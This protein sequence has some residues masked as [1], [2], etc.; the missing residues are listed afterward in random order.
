MLHVIKLIG[1]RFKYPVI[2][3]TQIEIYH[4][5][6]LANDDGMYLQNLDINKHTCTGVVVCSTV[7]VCACVPMWLCVHACVSVYVWLQRSKKFGDHN[8][9]R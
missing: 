2:R 9:R 4:L 5:W 1:N 3:N 6:K 7:W 8:C